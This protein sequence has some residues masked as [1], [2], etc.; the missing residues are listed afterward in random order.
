MRIKF[1]KGFTPEDVASI[2]LQI[3]G[4]RNLAIGSVNIYF[5]EYDEDCKPVNFDNSVEYL[6]VMPSQRS[7]QLYAEYVADL[8]R[9]RLKVI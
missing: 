1:K 3:V 2:F 8:R 7:E 9:S 5:Q 6:E 4:E